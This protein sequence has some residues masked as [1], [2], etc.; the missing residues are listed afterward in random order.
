MPP[1]IP[2][3]HGTKQSPTLP[4]S[5]LS[6]AKRQGTRSFFFFFISARRARRYPVSARNSRQ[7]RVNL[8][9]NFEKL[10]RALKISFVLASEQRE[11]EPSA[12]D[13]QGGARLGVTGYS[14]PGGG[15]ARAKTPPSTLSVFQKGPFTWTPRV[16]I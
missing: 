2:A 15:F 11:T 1:P 6:D 9:G 13:V 12:S 8:L 7:A 3:L 16:R 10:G 4:P 5:R 14:D